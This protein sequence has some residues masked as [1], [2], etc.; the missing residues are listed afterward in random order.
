[1]L[2]PGDKSIVEWVRTQLQ[3]EG[4]FYDPIFAYG[5]HID[6]KVVA[7]IVY[8]QA[9]NFDCHI[10]IASVSPQWASKEAIKGILGFP[11][12]TLKCRRITALTDRDNHNVRNFLKRLGF[13]HEG[14]LHDA[15]E[16]GDAV[17][18]GMTRRFYKRSKWHE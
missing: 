13:M 7:G 16:S 8:S 1:M 12:Q 15:R 18:Y 5:V 9:F 3:T 11:F 10:T 6:G 14:T 2:L 4:E 17:V